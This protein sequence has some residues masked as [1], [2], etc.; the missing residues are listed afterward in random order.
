MLEKS[1]L[2]EKFS[3]QTKKVMIES[4]GEEVEIKKLSI[5]QRQEVNEILFGNVTVKE[6]GK[7]R[8][9]SISNY[10]KAAKLGVS[11]GLVS[12]KLTIHDL[13][14]L[15]DNAAEFINEVFNAIQEFDEPKK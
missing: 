4:V 7:Q 1:A 14:K 15:A 10:N 5:A 3:L 12:P 6:A 11:Y 13:N 2:L 8:D 9:I